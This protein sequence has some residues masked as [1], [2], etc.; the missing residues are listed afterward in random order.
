MPIGLE[1]LRM[2][3]IQHK[4]QVYTFASCGAALSWS[5]YLD[6]CPVFLLLIIGFGN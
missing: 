5:E 2:W 3:Y 6:G 4:K 1:L